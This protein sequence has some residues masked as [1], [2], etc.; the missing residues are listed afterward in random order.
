MI[1]LKTLY[2]KFLFVSGQVNET[3]KV[4]SPL[5]EK[6]ISN[7]KEDDIIKIAAPAAPTQETVST[8][9]SNAAGSPEVELEPHEKAVVIVDE[10]PSSPS[11]MDSNEQHEQ[12]PPSPIPDVIVST[13]VEQ[14]CSR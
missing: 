6:S 12:Q 4:A 13:E 2:V 14:V 8:P 10:S 7:N 1:D 3:N 9:E 5:Q 11:A